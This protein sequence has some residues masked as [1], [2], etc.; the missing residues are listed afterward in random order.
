MSVVKGKRNESKVEF[1]DAYFKV[2]DDVV[3]QIKDNRFKTILVLLVWRFNKF[4]L[5]GQ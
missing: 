3:F 4:L 1:D 5:E 2:H